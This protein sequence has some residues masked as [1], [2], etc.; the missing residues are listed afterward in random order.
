M[1]TIN[2]AELN[3]MI[4]K[5]CNEVLSS[6]ISRMVDEK[7]EE[8][9]DDIARAVNEVVDLKMDKRIKEILSKR[10][11]K[12]KIVESA[13]RGVGLN[14]DDQYSAL[15]E[16]TTPR[17]HAFRSS[18]SNMQPPMRTGMAEAYLGELNRPQ[19]PHQPQ[20]YAPPE[21][22][23][24]GG[25]SIGGKTGIAEAYSA[26]FNDQGYIQP[27]DYTNPQDNNRIPS[28]DELMTMEYDEELLTGK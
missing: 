8:L 19:Q 18:L 5:V 22:F 9:S 3:Q 25:A 26:D 14:V 17:N 28:V 13:A 10:S 4:R 2:K 7:L 21:D 12:D 15:I 11:I 27:L 16:D 24:R 23:S 1:G 6:Q 20:A